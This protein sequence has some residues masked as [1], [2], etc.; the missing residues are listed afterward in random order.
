MRQCLERSFVRKTT[1][2]TSFGIFSSI[3]KDDCDQ[4]WNENVFFSLPAAHKSTLTTWKRR[5]RSTCTRAI[6]DSLVRLCLFLHS[7]RFVWPLAFEHLRCVRTKHVFIFDNGS[8]SLEGCPAS[9]TSPLPVQLT[10]EWWPWQN[11][12]MRRQRE[13]TQ[14]D[15]IEMKASVSSSHLVFFIDLRCGKGNNL[16]QTASAFLLFSFVRCSPRQKE[17]ETWPSTRKKGEE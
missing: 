9:L 5:R 10:P 4:Q 16:H 15:G 12:K 14:Y 13:K 8:G 11:R 17:K 1:W 3:R 7:C 2:T 6:G